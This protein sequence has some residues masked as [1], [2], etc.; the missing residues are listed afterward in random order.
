MSDHGGDWD[1]FLVNTDGGVVLLTLDDEAPAS[2]GLP[3]W[4]P[5]GSA[6]AF[7]SNRDGSWGLYLMA[8]DGSNARLALSIGTQHPNWLI[9]RLSWAP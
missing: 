3:A 5:D 8:P 2:D 6:I 1:V 9:E 7:I 4:A